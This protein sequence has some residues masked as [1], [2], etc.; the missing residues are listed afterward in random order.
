M[1]KKRGRPPKSPSP[2]FQSKSPNVS[3]ALETDDLVGFDED[4]VDFLNSLTPKKLDLM[5]QKLISFRDKVK[6]KAFVD[7]SN[8]NHSGPAVH[9]LNKN[10]ATNPI[11]GATTS[12]ASLDKNGVNN[13]QKRKTKQVW[14]EKK[15][16]VDS[17][18]IEIVDDPQK[19]EVEK[20]KFVEG[21]DLPDKVPETQDLIQQNPAASSSQ[22]AGKAVQD[23]EP[24]HNLYVETVSNDDEGQW[25]PARTRTRNQRRI[26][27]QK[28]VIPSLQPHG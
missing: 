15:K 8:V 26:D 12:S 25:T 17:E 10:G 7:D 23:G 19:L 27:A 24:S 20:E 22:S 6:G 4:D 2:P 21:D 13:L 16:P 11:S 28:G 1:A 5:L 14:V 18:V 3:K 9:G